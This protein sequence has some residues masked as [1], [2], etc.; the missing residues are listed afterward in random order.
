MVPHTG[1]MLFSR[2]ERFHA[3]RQEPTDGHVGPKKALLN[4]E[5]AILYMYIIS[6]YSIF[7]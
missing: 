2:K 1:Y 6:V 5:W 4:R 3:G 7:C